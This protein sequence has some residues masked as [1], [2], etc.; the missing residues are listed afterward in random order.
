MVMVQILVALALSQ[1]AALSTAAP[2]TA[3][4]TLV[5]GGLALITQTRALGVG[6]WNTTAT[7]YTGHTI[8]SWRVVVSVASRIDLGTIANIDYSLYD[9]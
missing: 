7:R 9:D 3:L 8:T 2:Q 6:F 4:A 5:D 1:E